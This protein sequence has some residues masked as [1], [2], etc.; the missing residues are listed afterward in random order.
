MA[1]NARK[2]DPDGHGLG[3]DWSGAFTATCVDTFPAGRRGKPAHDFDA[4]M[5][6]DFAAQVRWIRG[7]E[8]APAG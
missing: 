6:R 2:F 8:T 4:E 3:D 1:L 5:E 7:R